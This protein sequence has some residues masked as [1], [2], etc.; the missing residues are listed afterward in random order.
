MTEQT[1]PAFSGELRSTGYVPPAVAVRATYTIGDVTDE[2]TVE[3]AEWNGDPAVITSVIDALTEQRDADV[4]VDAGDAARP[5][6][7][8]VQHFAGD[9]A[10]TVTSKEVQA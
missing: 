3:I 9:P 8:I 6:L 5:R 4:Q 7:N 2:I 10:T 1:E